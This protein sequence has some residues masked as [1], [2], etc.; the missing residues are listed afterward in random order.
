ME[1]FEDGFEH[2]VAAEDVMLTCSGTHAVVHVPHSRRGMLGFDPIYGIKNA[3][4][5]MN[6]KRNISIKHSHARGNE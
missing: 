4:P 6:L 1:L 3:N 5:R 2:V